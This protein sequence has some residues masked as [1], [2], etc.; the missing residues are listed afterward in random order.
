MDWNESMG[1]H[2]C[3][4]V[5]YYRKIC[6]VDSLLLF[7]IHIFLHDINRC[8]KKYWIGW[9]DGAT[10]NLGVSHQNQ[11]WVAN[12]IINP[13]LT[14]LVMEDSISRK[15]QENVPSAFVFHLLRW[16]ILLENAPASLPHTVS[17]C[18][19]H[20]NSLFIKLLDSLWQ[21]HC[22]IWPLFLLLNEALI[23]SPGL[24]SSAP[25]FGLP[26]Q[27]TMCCLLIVFF[28]M[29]FWII[30]LFRVMMASTPL[31]W[32]YFNWQLVSCSF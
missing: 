25:G 31:L 7:D 17:Q 14:T 2:L 23:A 27:C 1:V 5:Q 19:Q 15:V 20:Y 11:K 24:L 18:I 29:Y 32:M 22:Y 10:E 28:F 6:F 9:L 8:P 16:L 4:S 26:V 13:N 3:E 12:L 30:P 21:K